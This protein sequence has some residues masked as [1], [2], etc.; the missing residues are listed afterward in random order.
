MQADTPSQETQVTWAQM[1]LLARRYRW[2][3]LV[4]AL[5]VILGAYVTLLFVSDQYQSRAS[6]L[7]KLGREN[8]ELPTTVQATGSVA[9]GLRPEELN[10]EVQILKSRELMAGVVDRLGVEAFSV[11][12]PEPH[13]FWQTLKYRRKRATRWLK[14]KEQDALVALGLDKRITPRENA[15]LTLERAVDAAPEKISDV[16][17]VTT[18]LP[19]ANLAKR[20]E[21]TVL[22]LYLEQRADL[23]RNPAETSFF[24]AELE[25]HGAELAA[26][27]QQRND[28]RTR[29]HLTEIQEQKSLL[30]KQESDLQTQVSTDQGSA[31]TLKQQQQA[32]LS[33]LHQ[34]NV[35]VPVNQ[36]YTPNPA[37]QSYKERVSQL[38]LE[39]AK[40]LS[41]YQ[42]GSE[43]I[44]R[45]DEEI[46]SLEKLMTSEPGTLVGSRT[47]EPNPT[48]RQF[49]QNLESNQVALAGLEAHQASLR[50]TMGKVS[51][52]LGSLSD[53]ERQLE[54]VNRRFQLAQ[55]SYLDVARRAQEARL[56]EH[57]DENHM[58]N[59]R[60]LADPSTPIEP[61]APRRVVIMAASLPLGLLLGVALALLLHY[62]DDTIHGEEEM[63][64][65]GLRVLGT[66][67][68]PGTLLPQE[69]AAVMAGGTR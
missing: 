69:R 10:S 30:L 67:R 38:Q 29:Y 58:A 59:V 8:I 66:Y 40:A 55:D 22:M 15:I 53:G 9:T 37:V 19:D 61:V 54:D 43:P 4:T 42:P 26:L 51:S 24:K 11:S 3:V 23:R 5:T 27:E 28:L 13:G 64:G 44:R 68:K 62:M 1:R 60:M 12:L 32:M 25:Q 34:L 65:L 52:N 36:V 63:D 6:L 17:T 39:R 7:V 14:A 48:G 21:Q 46:S 45:F 56:H 47:E 16:I 49:Q 18:Q 57:L 50:S 31:A 41:K 35:Q 2:V 33:R 20:V